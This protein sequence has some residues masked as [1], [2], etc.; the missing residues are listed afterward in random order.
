MPVANSYPGLRTILSDG[1]VF[2]IA[3]LCALV[4]AGECMAAADKGASS[5]ASF[6]L[7]SWNVYQQGTMQENG[8]ETIVGEIVR[9]KPDLAVLVEVRNYG[10][11]D[12]L[13][14]LVG[15]LAARGE[16]Y[17]THWSEGAGVISRTPFADTVIW[18]GPRGNVRKAVTEIGGSAIALYAGHLDASHCAYYGAYR[19]A[20]K[21]LSERERQAAVAKLL[22]T[23]TVSDRDNMAYAV[24]NDA[25]QELARGRDV[26]FCGDFNETSH[27][28][29]TWE[30]RDVRSHSGF[31]VP[32]TVSTALSGDGFID[33][34]RKL[35]P[36]ALT[37]PGITYPAMMDGKDPQRI[38]WD[39]T[40][41]ERERIDFIHYKGTRIEVADIKIYGPRDS[42]GFGRAIREDTQDPFL[43]PQG[44][45]P[46]DHKGLW[47]KFT[48]KEEGEKQ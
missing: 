31:V 24:L 39:K 3:G 35:Y 16:N 7:L 47:A 22:K 4:A 17:Y 20:D 25:R 37:H 1:R 45:W 19:Y 34:Y 36:D 44:L 13:A 8:Y 9:L 26:I 33:A 42:V 18:P 2:A 12:W 21:T 41:D 11:K 43:P 46:S 30:T 23:N 15:D 29:W 27:L 48:I 32:W 6:T 40:A 10:K 38:A 14:R 5:P 28:D